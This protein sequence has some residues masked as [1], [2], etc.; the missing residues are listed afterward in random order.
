MLFLTAGML[1]CI[2][3][4]TNQTLSTLK[5]LQE[6]SATTES[7]ALACQR[8]ATELREAV[9]VPDLS[10]GVAFRK[11]RPNVPPVMG[12]TIA[13][14]TWDLSYRPTFL[15][16]VRYVQSGEQVMRQVN[17]EEPLE[18]ASRVNTFTV[19]RFS[20]GNG[21]YRIALSIMEKRRAVV[22]ET[23]AVCPGVW[24]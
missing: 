21:A 22:F 15:A 20:G 18:V 16:T 17:S 19:T 4:L 23:V 24:P 14:S 6:K 10:N 3:K 9:S 13:D 8:L 1:F 7:A 5:F 12:Q 2:A 11:V